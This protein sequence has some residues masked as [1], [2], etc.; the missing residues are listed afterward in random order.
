M[1]KT[2]QVIRNNWLYTGD[3]G[4]LDTEGNLYFV[5]RKEESIRVKGEWVHVHAVEAALTS[6]PDVHACA[7][8]GI[9]GGVGGDEVKAYIKLRLGKVTKPED[10]IAHCEGKIADYMIPRYIEFVDELPTTSSTGTVQ[11][12]LLKAK[13]IENAWDRE[14][15]GYKLKRL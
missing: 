1:T 7:V 9:S 8:V 6:H 4:Y 10:I 14:K 3:V 13:G 11:K 12:S 5:H 15:A 2:A